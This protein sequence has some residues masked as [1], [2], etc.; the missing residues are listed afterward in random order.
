MV[1]YPI[2]LLLIPYQA[3]SILRSQDKMLLVIPTSGNKTLKTSE[4]RSFCVAEPW[5]W[6]DLP[7]TVK[8]TETVSSFKKALKTH[9]FYIPHGIVNI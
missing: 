9:L 2:N 3:Q 1:L 8:C 5:L 4:E 6:Y 7:W